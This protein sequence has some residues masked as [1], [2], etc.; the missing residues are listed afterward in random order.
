MAARLSFDERCVISAMVGVGASARQ[1]AD[2][3][4]R[5]SSTVQREI[6][7]AG[8]RGVYRAEAINPDYPTDVGSSLF[9]LIVFGVPGLLFVIYGA[10]AV[11]AKR[12]IEPR[13]KQP[14]EPLLEPPPSE[15]DHYL[16][17]QDDPPKSP[18][19]PPEP[20]PSEKWIPVGEPAKKPKQGMSCRDC[21]TIV[22]KSAKACPQC[23][24]KKPATGK[25][26][27]AIRKTGNALL[28]IGLILVLAQCAIYC[29]E[30]AEIASTL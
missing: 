15:L 14:P 28:I 10:K 12:K 18:P 13:H 26:A 19:K 23:G 30:V 17:L 11:K 21:G 6:N 5:H 9:A 3:L 7:R 25:V 20:Q 4:G 29:A 16:A 1:I 24:A 8:G 27:W 2:E 22:S